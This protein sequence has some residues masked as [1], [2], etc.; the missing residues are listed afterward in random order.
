MS[1]VMVFP[2]AVASVDWFQGAPQVTQ[3]VR[4]ALALALSPK[5][6]GESSPTGSLLELQAPEVR[7]VQRHGAL[8]QLPGP[9]AEKIAPGFKK[10]E[11]RA[12]EVQPGAN[13]RGG[14]F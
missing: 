13:K 4:V 7:Q 14:P 6:H 2:R 10:K 8:Q 1:T 5:G 9:G 3:V 12:G 11:N